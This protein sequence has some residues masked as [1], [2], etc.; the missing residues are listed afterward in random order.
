[1]SGGVRDAMISLEPDELIIDNFAGGGGA[2]TGIE[3]A[4][5]RP[6]DIA[7]NHDPEAIA[8]HAANHPRTL[9]L[10]ESV[11][12]VDIRKVVA[13]RKVGLAWFSPDCK[14]NA[15]P[16]NENLAGRS[17]D[18]PIST[19][20]ARGTQQTI[21]AS[22]LLKLRGTCRDGQPTD[23]P[24]ATISAQGTHLAEVRAFLLKYYGTDQDPDLREPLH[25]VTT[26]PRFGLV[27]V[28][29]IDYLIVDI[30]M[31]MLTPRELFRAQGFPDSYVIAHGLRD[32]KQIPLTKS[33]QVRMCGN[34]VSPHPA[35][36]IVAAQF[37]TDRAEAAA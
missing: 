31:R 21:I 9:H 17:L 26:K 19:I 32:G 34:S 2:S 13:G 8:M 18:E 3:M 27:T 22:H 6:I 35:A 29:G 36:A 12:K 1:M 30:G 4:L 33:A 10:C 11:W 23:E 25:T 28:K 14:H 15:G 5:G 7:V 20:T 37:S 24:L 16:H